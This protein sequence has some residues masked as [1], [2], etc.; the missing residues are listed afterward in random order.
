VTETTE[1]LSGRAPFAAAKRS[2]SCDFAHISN[3]HSTDMWFKQF[4]TQC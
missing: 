1:K 4:K 2:I 3:H